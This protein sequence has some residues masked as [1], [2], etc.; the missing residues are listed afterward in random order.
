[1][2]TIQLAAELTQNRNYDLRHKNRISQL[3]IK[4]CD[5][6][7]EWINYELNKYLQNAQ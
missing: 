7:I 5:K 2:D 6:I 4:F 1:M 3:E